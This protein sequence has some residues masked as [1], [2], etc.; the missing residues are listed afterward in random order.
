MLGK[1]RGIAGEPEEGGEE[2]PLEKALDDLR[3]VDL[4]RVDSLALV[5]CIVKA[6][7]SLEIEKLRSAGGAWSEP[8]T[9][10]RLEAI[11]KQEQGMGRAA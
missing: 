5:E 11:R 2:E 3:R 8:E 4:R 10:A 1:L 7:R 9:A 6:Q